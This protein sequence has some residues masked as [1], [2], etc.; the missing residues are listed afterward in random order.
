MALFIEIFRRLQYHI[1]VRVYI[2]REVV[3]MSSGLQWAQ[4]MGMAT[5]A[6]KKMLF[7]MLK[8]SAK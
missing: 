5:M 3:Y 2:S 8:G 6:N 1:Y 7:V 4:S